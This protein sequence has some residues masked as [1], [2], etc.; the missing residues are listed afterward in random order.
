MRIKQQNRPRCLVSPATTHGVKA[1][2]PPTL[3]KPRIRTPDSIHQGTPAAEPA[4]DLTLDLQGTAH[5]DAES[6]AAVWNQCCR[7][8]VTPSDRHL[9]GYDTG[10]GRSGAETHKRNH[11][12]L[13][14]S[15]CLE[16]PLF[17][18]KPNVTFTRASFK[19]PAINYI[20]RAR[21]TDCATVQRGQAGA[22]VH[23][24]YRKMPMY[25]KN[26]P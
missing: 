22:V 4:L 5:S 21:V 7:I 26:R 25:P 8:L 12:R 1:S 18:V 13:H 16:S 17:H 2:N 24:P 23:D 10:N 19:Q 11:L 9:L 6:A 15:A 20:L 14:D 3:C